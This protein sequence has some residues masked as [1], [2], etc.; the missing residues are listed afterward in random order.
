MRI[1]KKEEWIKKQE[2]YEDK[3]GKIKEALKAKR[4]ALYL[5]LE[6]I[7]RVKIWRIIFACFVLDQHFTSM[8]CWIE[9]WLFDLKNVKFLLNRQDTQAHEE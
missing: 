3:I 4:I 6:M 7:H 5:I 1:E 8:L 2:F 9:T